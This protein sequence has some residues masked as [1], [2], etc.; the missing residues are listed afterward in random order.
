[1]E[2]ENILSPSVDIEDGAI[3]MA[4][5][6]VEWKLDRSAFPVVISTISQLLIK[7]PH[8]YLAG[9]LTSVSRAR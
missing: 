6:G 9:A 4:K 1:M 8:N 5:D 3:W 7:L 2:I